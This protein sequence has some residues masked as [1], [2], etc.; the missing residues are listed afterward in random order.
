MYKDRFTVVVKMPHRRLR[1]QE[2]EKIE[3]I[4]IESIEEHA[5]LGG[6]GPEDIEV[7]VKGPHKQTGT[8]L[9]EGTRIC[10]H[11]DGVS[12]QGIVNTAVN[13]GSP[14]DGD[15]WY[16]EFKTPAGDPRYWKQG[17]DGGRLE[18]LDAED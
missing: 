13:Y 18:V 5:R 16:I 8:S 10:V 3:K 2:C 4:I 6:M 15:N 1:L 7:V 12:I 17:Y 9:P 14:E 11:H